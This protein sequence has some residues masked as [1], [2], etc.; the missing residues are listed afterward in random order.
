MEI[1]ITDMGAAT[2]VAPLGSIDALT[3]EEL[4]QAVAGQTGQGKKNLV[5]DLGQVDFM[6]SAGLRA[7]LAGVK[8][9][10]T[11]GGDLRIAAAQAGVEKVLKLSG[12]NTILKTYPQ[13]QQAVQSYA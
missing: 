8:D 11:L 13:V 9:C 12:F 5:L 4:T 1:Q 2:V 7:I 3:A 10:R 6:S